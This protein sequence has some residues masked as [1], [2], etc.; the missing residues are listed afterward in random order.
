MSSIAAPKRT[1]GLAP[2]WK[3]DRVVLWLRTAA[4][5]LILTLLLVSFTPF[6][7]ESAATAEGGNVVNQLGYGG[8]AALAIAGLLTFADR[9]AAFTLLR[10]TWVL[11]GGWMVFSATQSP[12]PDASM[13][14]VVFSILAMI[15]AT[16]AVCLPPNARSFRFALSFAALTVLGLSYLGL[17]VFPAA[18]IHGAS[19]AEPEHAGLWRGIYS[20][21]NVAAPVMAALFFAGLYLL[22]SGEKWRGWAILVL[23]AVF[24][25]KTGSKTSAGLVPL[26]AILVIGGRTVGGRALPA[27]ML[28]ATACIMALLTLGAAMSPLLD[29]VLQ[30]ILPGTTFTGRMD[31]WRFALDAMQGQQ[32]TGWGFESFWG[33]GVVRGIERPFELSWDPRG[34]VNSHSG[35][36]EIAIA[37]G[38]PALGLA[39]FL[40]L[41]LPVA[42]YLRSK[43]G[44][45][46]QCFADFCLMV[47][48]FVLLNSFLESYLFARAHPTWMLAFMSIVGLRLGAR[49]RMV[50]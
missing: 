41:F 40:L 10:P 43:P 31:L 30:T 27:L 18:A 11:F 26:V 13:R 1:D 20:H 21:K 45:E 4:A 22:R 25:A 34:I 44:A 17:V 15:T 3:A 50:P 14:A 47:L 36:L 46:N 32:W 2:D 8:L 19:G 48:S 28:V 39:S 16:G 35:Y 37:M 24:I 9:G 23:S 42:D 12:V 7:V 29:A 6:E 38:W 33:T 5:T 49:L